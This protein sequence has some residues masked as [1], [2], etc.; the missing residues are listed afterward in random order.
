MDATVYDFDT[1][2]LGDQASSGKTMTET[3]I[4]LFAA[5]SADTNPLHINAEFAERSIFKGRVAQGMLTSAL[6]SSVIGTRMPG[7]GTILLSQHLRYRAPVRIGETVNATVEVTG[8]DPQKRRAT[9]RAICEV[10]GKIVIEGEV[11]VIPPSRE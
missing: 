6:I 7:P 5:A 2:R 9:L 10:N 1:L 4:L 3:D 8:L 11:V